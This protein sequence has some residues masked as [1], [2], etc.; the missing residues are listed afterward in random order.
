MP[1]DDWLI[2]TLLEPDSFASGSSWVSSSTPSET[3]S[4]SGVSLLLFLSNVRS[5]SKI[6]MID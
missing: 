6:L 1:S 2:T 3:P 4:G 5:L